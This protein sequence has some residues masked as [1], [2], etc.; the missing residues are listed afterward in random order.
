MPHHVLAMVL[1]EKRSYLGLPASLVWTV[2]QCLHMSLLAP[3]SRYLIHLQAGFVEFPS[4]PFLLFP[5]SLR[6]RPITKEKNFLLSQFSEEQKHPQCKEP[7]IGCPSSHAGDIE[8]LNFINCRSLSHLGLSGWSFGTGNRDDGTF[9]G[10][11]SSSEFCPLGVTS[12]WILL[13]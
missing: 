5:C 8:E 6:L 10:F 7:V 9:S 11:C 3:A 4:F 1:R 13:H 2:H 12:M